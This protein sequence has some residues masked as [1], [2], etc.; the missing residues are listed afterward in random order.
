MNLDLGLAVA[1]GALDE[2][3]ATLDGLF[4]RDSGRLFEVVEQR[5]L[6]GLYRRMLGRL[7][8]RLLR[9]GERELL[10]VVARRRQQRVKLARHVPRL[11]AISRIILSLRQVPDMALIYISSVR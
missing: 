9:L 7:L 10:H 1:H 2:S 11:Q 8:G 3:H 4:I 5:L 6:L